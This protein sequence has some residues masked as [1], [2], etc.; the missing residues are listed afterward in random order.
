MCT[1][2]CRRGRG[3][4][5]SLCLRDFGDVRQLL[6]TDVASIDYAVDCHYNAASDELTLFT[7]N[8]E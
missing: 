8:Y 7:G 5:Q 4:N 3:P 6:S 2:R 1:S